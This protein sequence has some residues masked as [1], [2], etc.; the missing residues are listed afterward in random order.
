[1]EN[2][3]HDINQ[4]HNPDLSIEASY[5]CDRSVDFFLDHQPPVVKAGIE[6]PR[7]ARNYVKNTDIKANNC[8]QP[9]R[10]E[11]DEHG[12]NDFIG[13]SLPR[14]KRKFS[15]TLENKQQNARGKHNN[16]QH[17]N[18]DCGT[19][20][21]ENIG[22]PSPPKDRTQSLN[23]ISEQSIE[24]NNL[25]KQNQY[26]VQDKSEPGRK[27]LNNL[28]IQNPTT[29]N[30]NHQAVSIND[31]GIIPRVPVV[32][33]RNQEA[34]VN[35]EELDIT[36]PV[37]HRRPQEIDNNQQQVNIEEEKETDRRE[38]EKQLKKF[39]SSAAKSKIRT[40][41]S[42][43]LTVFGGSLVLLCARSGSLLYTDLFIVSYISAGF[44][45]L[46][47][48]IQTI[49]YD[50]LKWKRVEDISKTLDVLSVV[51]ALVISHLKIS[52]INIS[53]K[54]SLILPAINLIF[55]AYKSTITKRLKSIYFTLRCIATLQLALLTIKLDQDIDWPWELIL[56]FAW[57]FLGLI[58]VFCVLVLLTFISTI[59]GAI[60]K[61]NM[62]PNVGISAQIIGFFWMSIYSGLGVV[63]F[64]ILIGAIIAFEG[65][66]E[67]SSAFFSVSLIVGCFLSV[68][69]TLLT[70]GTYPVL[71][72]FL[73]KFDSDEV[74]YREL[75][76]IPVISEADYAITVEKKPVYLVKLSSTFFSSFNKSLASVNKDLQQKLKKDMKQIQVRR[77][78]RKSAHI[79]AV[80]H[81]TGNNKTNAIV[82]I[83]TLRREKQELD[84]IFRPKPI[85]DLPKNF[86]DIALRRNKSEL[87]PQKSQRD[88][89]MNPSGVHNIDKMCLSEG[90]HVDHSI[91]EPGSVQSISEN[92]CYIC[93]VRAPNAV[94]FECGHGGVCLECAVETI[95]AKGQC[96]ECRGGVK[97]VI[98]I[99]P[100]PIMNDIIKGSEIITIP[101]RAG[102]GE[103]DMPNDSG[104]QYSNSY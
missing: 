3:H 16:G 93:C 29:D 82:N 86:T 15:N 8:S 10:L 47:A 23:K 90:I 78:R 41:F 75:L 73:L 63:A 17:H 68:F 2:Q 97:K 52:G 74:E 79:T 83:E 1:M 104:Y 33:N 69:L 88:L 62:A 19:N 26:I 46:E 43:Y 4:K 42:A 40:A 31:Q 102:G 39:L 59:T 71:I 98:R 13:I 85:L 24:L 57:F 7:L 50:P 64:M 28:T 54:F 96:M 60:F 81:E 44:F 20:H 65:N 84:K 76:G 6:S 22:S 100:E 95:Q 92:C 67:D 49:S 34:I 80:V 21:M 101:Q 32:N 61:I 45:F 66:P 18:S 37:T 53:L 36:I 56:A 87:E 25:T 12:N 94:T 77:F 14:P 30:E 91:S 51:S 11:M 55:Y 72:H 9:F 5:V 35:V 38:R 27:S 99:D 89:T 58:G 48:I 70:V 103:D